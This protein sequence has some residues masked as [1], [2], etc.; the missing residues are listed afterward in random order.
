MLPAS[1][2]G[3]DLMPVW[4]HAHVIFGFIAF[5]GFI[6]GLVWVIKFADQKT[7]IKWAKWT[8][9]I[10]I[11]GLL[12]TASYS[13]MGWGYMKMGK[14]KGYMMERMQECTEEGATCE[15]GKMF[16]EMMK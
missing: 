12:L 4:L 6:A 14:M 1:F 11:I 10:G 7:V 2:A 3:S 13:M 5:F 9:A 8:I 15:F 16:E